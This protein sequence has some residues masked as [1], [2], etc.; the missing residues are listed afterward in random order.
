MEKIKLYI[1]IKEDG[2][3]EKLMKFIAEKQNPYIEVGLLTTLGEK[4]EFRH[5]DFVVS[6]DFESIKGLRCNTIEIVKSPDAE[7]EKTLFM[8]QSREKIYHKLLGL[9]GA[10]EWKKEKE[11]D[12]NTRMIC[13]FSPGGGDERT[14]L[15]LHKALESAEWGKTLYISLCEFPIFA[16]ENEKDGVK[17]PG[18]SELI[19]CAK[20]NVFYEKLEELAFLKGTVWMVAPAGHYKDLLDYPLEEMMQFAKKVREQRL[21][22]VVIFEIGE[23][24]EYTLEFLANADEVIVP[25]ET[26]I[27]AGDRK[28]RFQKYCIREGH[29]ELW[30]RLQFVSRTWHEEENEQIGQLLYGEERGR[31]A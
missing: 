30:E 16:G 23:L 19:L 2:Y 5:N 7:M 28:D 10:G 26:G 27:F 15:A 21:F 24:F 11:K 20:S 18:L 4:T 22:D 25:E 29:E 31:R 12:R 17:M 9:T 3:G 14:F 6:D 1:R 8:Y 13:V